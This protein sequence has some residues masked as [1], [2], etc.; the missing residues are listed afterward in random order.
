MYSSHRVLKIV[1]TSCGIIICA[2]FNYSVVQSSTICFLRF[3]NSCVTEHKS[4]NSRDNFKQNNQSEY[5]GIL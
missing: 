2:K 4:N 3:I 1:Y 5:N